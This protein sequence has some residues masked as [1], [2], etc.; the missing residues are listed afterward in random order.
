MAATASLGLFWGSADAGR[1][2]PTVENPYCEVTTYTLRDVPEQASSMSDSSGRPVI[3]VNLAT[4]RDDPSY[5]RFLMAHECCHHT[6]GHVGKYREGLGHIGPQPFFY[7]APAL[8]QMELDADCC[9]VKLLRQRH[10]ADSIEAARSTMV[11]F[12]K[13]PTG[14]YYPTGEERAANISACATQAE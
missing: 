13:Q 14:A 9:A 5:G 12:G 1:W 4:L 3:V 7:I 6:L 2:L 11:T 10:E 8:K